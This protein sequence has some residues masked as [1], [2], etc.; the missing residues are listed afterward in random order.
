MPYKDR[1]RQSKAQRDWY[2]KN[3]ARIMLG[4][5][6]RRQ[7]RYRRI[8]EWK[9]KRGCARCGYKAHARAL[10]IHHL[11][12]SKKGPKSEISKMA[13]NRV[14]WDKILAALESPDVEVIC[15]NCHR[16]EHFNNGF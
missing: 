2:I 14:K 10:D 8:N 16:I 3:K 12:G 5:E 13:Q 7:D 4:N 15:S 9:L 11:N 6:A 1:E